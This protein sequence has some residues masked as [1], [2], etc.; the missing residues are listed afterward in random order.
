[1]RGSEFGN[2]VSGSDWTLKELDVDRVM[3][4]SLW[5]DR[6]RFVGILKAV[7]GRKKVD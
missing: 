4:C 7:Q 3:L 2:L 1:V 5:V 6:R